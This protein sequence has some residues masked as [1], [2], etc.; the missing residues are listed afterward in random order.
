MNLVVTESWAVAESVFSVTRVAI[1]LCAVAV[2]SGFLLAISLPLAGFAAAGY[3]LLYLA[4][5][6]PPRW[7]RDIGASA[8][9]ISR[10]MALQVLNALQSMRTIRVFAQEGSV[11]DRFRWVSLRVRRSHA[12][13]DRLNCWIGFLN[14]VGLLI[15]LGL[16]VFLAARLGI[17]A[18]STLAVVA[19]M[20]RLHLTFGNSK[21]R[22]CGSPVSRPPSTL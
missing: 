22:I 12:Q 18:T 15:V 11:R 4:L 14:E 19:L 9:K 13:L 6:I 17:S 2:F 7:A 16:V 3:A 8:V 10:D 21:L 1:N 20:Y 5:R